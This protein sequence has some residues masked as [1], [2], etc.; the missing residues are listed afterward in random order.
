MTNGFPHFSAFGLVAQC[1][2]ALSTKVGD[3]SNAA[4][5]VLVLISNAR[6]PAVS[7][8]ELPLRF[9]DVHVNL[10]A[11]REACLQGSHALDP[12]RLR[13]V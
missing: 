6:D 12:E 8:D 13:Q 11:A 10:C 1:D 2:G 7:K 5:Q 9:P 3:R 4:K